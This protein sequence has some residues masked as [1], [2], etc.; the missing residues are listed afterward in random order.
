[1]LVGEAR[2]RLR[3]MGMHLHFCQSG[4]PG[5]ERWHAMAVRAAPWDPETCLMDAVASEVR[6]RSCSRVLERVVEMAEE[7]AGMKDG[8]LIGY[9]KE[10]EGGGG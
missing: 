1:M 4:V 10:E 5:P 2:S 6:D 8:E 9:G 7:W 3:A